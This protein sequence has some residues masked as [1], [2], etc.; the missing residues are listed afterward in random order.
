[1]RFRHPSLTS[2][3]ALPVLGGRVCQSLRQWH[4]ACTAGH[5]NPIHQQ[6]HTSGL[7]EACTT[8]EYGHAPSLGN[9]NARALARHSWPP[10]IN[11]VA[12]TSPVCTLGDR[13]RSDTV[14]RPLRN[15]RRTSISGPI[16]TRL[17]RR[18]RGPPADQ[19]HW[20]KDHLIAGCSRQSRATAKSTSPDAR[21]AGT[22]AHSHGSAPLVR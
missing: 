8:N 16:A 17:T 12:W 19:V 4:L 9:A 20:S 7:S 13:Q 21:Q 2:R 3:H 5:S 6:Y 22:A 10:F 15:L 11:V 18:L 14:Q 1:M